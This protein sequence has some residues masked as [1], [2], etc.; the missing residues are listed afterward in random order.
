MHLGEYLEEKCKD[1]IKIVSDPLSMMITGGI[2]CIYNGYK[3]L[4]TYVVGESITVSSENKGASALVEL[5]DA[6]SEVMGAEPICSYLMQS[7]GSR[8]EDS[9]P[10]MEWDINKPEERI[11]EVVNGRAFPNKPEIHNIVLYGERNI[12]DYVET[13][14]EKQARIANARIY[15]K[16]PGHL[17]NLEIYENMAEVEL[18]FQ[19]DALGGHIWRCRHDM[20]PGRIPKIDLTEE[21]YALEY[22]VY[23][24]TRFGVE[25]PEPEIDNHVQVTPSYQAWYSFYSNH[26]KE[27]LTQEQWDAFMLAREEGKDVSA[28]LPSG[29]WRNLLDPEKE[30]GPKE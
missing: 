27:V 28:F 6:F 19:I 22:L 13:E 24:T 5:K 29:S 12:E 15:G 9:N 20:K 21:E 26:F 30:I 16:D 7:I 17:T 11:K 23:Q 2:E 1:K 8:L 18:F 14:A 3:V 25:I 4:I 10:T